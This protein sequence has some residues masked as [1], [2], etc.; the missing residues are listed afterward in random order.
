MKH[1]LI[2]S[3]ILIFL[4][5]SFIYI[6][7]SAAI[8]EAEK[9]YNEAEK[10]WKNY[11]TR[12]QA[13][14]IYQRILDNYPESKIATEA[15]YRLE[16]H[17]I[18][19]HS[20]SGGYCLPSEKIKMLEK[21]ISC[22]NKSGIKLKN[23]ENRYFIFGQSYINVG[24]Y[25]KAIKEFKKCKYNHGI[26]HAQWLKDNG[27]IKSGKV[28]IRQYLGESRLDVSKTGEIVD[29]D[30]VWTGYFKGPVIGYNKSKNTHF[31]VYVPANIYKGPGP[32][33]A[34]ECFLWIGTG[35]DGIIR[36]DKEKQELKQIT[37]IDSIPL[38]TVRKLKIS[39][40]DFFIESV[41]S[42]KRIETK[43]RIHRYKSNPSLVK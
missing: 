11:D 31:I 10:L 26:E 24:E 42:L 39:Y 29:G 28:K 14:E 13:V 21:Y 7:E 9:L 15:Y 34:D 8:S 38:K 16:Y 12:H 37:N 20:G 43:I 27:Y 23:E 36:F 32:L 35:G 4:V 17:I 22:F 30:Y 18:G 40:D 3:V 19:G 25:D 6:E 5:S 33:V 41:D 2:I 1:S